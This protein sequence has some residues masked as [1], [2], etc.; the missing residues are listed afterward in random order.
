EDF[1]RPRLVRVVE[2]TVFRFTRKPMSLGVM[3]IRTNKIISDEESVELGVE[4][5]LEAKK[6]SEAKIEQ[7]IDSD[8]KGVSIWSLEQIIERDILKDYN[9]DD[10]YI[11]EVS[12]LA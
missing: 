10:T 2:N 1:N 6:S 4:K 8:A 3:Q 11:S 12:E 5:I 9:P 7:E